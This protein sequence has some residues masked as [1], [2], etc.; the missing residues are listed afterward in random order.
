MVR[1]KIEDVLSG[2]RLMA[3]ESSASNL[4]RN[5]LFELNVAARLWRAGL[6]PELGVGTDVRVEVEQNV[7]LIEGKRPLGPGGV[8]KCI[9][10]ARRQ[11]LSG[12]K[13]EP[14]GS[15]GIVARSFTRLVTEKGRQ[16]FIAPNELAGKLGLRDLLEE[17]AAEYQDA[18]N[19]L[20][21]HVV[22]ILFHG[23]G[24]MQLAREGRYVTGQVTNMRRFAPLGSRDALVFEALWRCRTPTRS[25]S[26][27][28][29]R[30]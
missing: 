12:A 3:D 1:Q 13:K 4:A 19:R 29:P 9:K 6:E 17:A 5:T 24:L 25:N 16:Y 15:R 18:W 11:I 20:G 26:K 22:G 2:P 21:H 8:A 30:R 10:E 28:C 23:V 27:K 14:A 7:L